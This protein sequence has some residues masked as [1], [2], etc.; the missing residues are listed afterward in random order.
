MKKV[1]E[2]VLYTE[3]NFNAIK[4]RFNEVLNEF[5]FDNAQI[6]SFEIIDDTMNLTCPPGYVLREVCDP[7]TGKCTLKCVKAS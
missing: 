4:Q 1:N 6:K 5:G 7:I 3:G 2:E